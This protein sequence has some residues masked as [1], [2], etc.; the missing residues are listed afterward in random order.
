MTGGTDQPG[1]GTD[2]ITAAAG[3]VAAEAEA[4]LTKHPDAA[5][6]VNALLGQLA[7]FV[8][9]A[10]E[11]LRATEAAAREIGSKRAERN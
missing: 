3:R 11:V 2:P 5:P 8:G 7:A 1:P 9:Q 10:R 6:A 4:L